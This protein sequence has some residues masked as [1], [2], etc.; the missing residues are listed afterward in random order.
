MFPRFSNWSLTR[1]DCRPFEYPNF[2]AYASA[3]N[4]FLRD[5]MFIKTW[6]KW[7][8][9]A[10]IYTQDPWLATVVMAC[11]DRRRAHER[12]LWSRQCQTC[13]TILDLPQYGVTRDPK[14]KKLK[15]VSPSKKEDFVD[16][17]GQV[18]LS[19]QASPHVLTHY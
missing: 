1:P 2:T 5:S 9:G 15:R 3:W 16:T 8:T 11:I 13:E 14:R 17:I 10:H 19:F 7:S 4:S 18:L 6:S 12:R